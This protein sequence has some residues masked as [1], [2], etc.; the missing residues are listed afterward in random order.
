MTR[1]IKPA[2]VDKDTRHG[3]DIDYL[4]YGI[5]LPNG[6]IWWS[7]GLPPSPQLRG[8][9]FERLSL[10]VHQ[11]KAQLAYAEWLERQGVTYDPELHRLRFIQRRQQIR[12]TEPETLAGEELREFGE[13]A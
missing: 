4:E 3:E 13:K 2:D 8:V 10:Q 11:D 7:T 12:Y 6:K 9:K 1:T 5:Q